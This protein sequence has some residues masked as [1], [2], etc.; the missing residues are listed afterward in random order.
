MDRNWSW[1]SGTDL[2]Y[3]PP[4]SPKFIKIAFFVKSK[5]TV[6]VRNGRLG[7]RGPAIVPRGTLP[8]V[9]YRM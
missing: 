2:L 7:A 1:N 5:H 3:M 9:V 8:N 4:A 6:A